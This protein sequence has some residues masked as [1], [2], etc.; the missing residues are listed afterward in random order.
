[1]VNGFTFANYSSYELLDRMNAAV[2]LWHDA[3]KRRALVKKIMNTDFSWRAS[4]K[5]YI[6]MY[7]ELCK[8]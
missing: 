6:G 7:A 4:A 3:K 8:K 5:S 2:G 1:M